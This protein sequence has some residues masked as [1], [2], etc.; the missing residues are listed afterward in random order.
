MT[1]GNTDM[2]LIF[3]PHDRR[4]V[5]PL[6]L[7]LNTIHD[8]FSHMAELHFYVYRMIKKPPIEL[9][10]ISDDDIDYKA[11][12]N[13]VEN[14]PCSILYIRLGSSMAVIAK[15]VLMHCKV[16]L[17]VEFITGGLFSNKYGMEVP[18]QTL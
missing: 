14:P 16:P 2:K 18:N 17:K 13:M 1:E 7:T 9:T 5:R 11:I 3:V 15:E 4:S 12:N 10:I 8:P 6:P